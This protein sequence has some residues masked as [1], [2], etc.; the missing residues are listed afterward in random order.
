MNR[1][2]IAGVIWSVFTSFQAIFFMVL[3]LTS[4]AKRE[5][6]TSREWLGR[7]GFPRSAR[8]VKAK[9]VLVQPPALLDDR[10][11][12]RQKVFF[13]RRR[14]GHRRIERR[15]ACHGRIE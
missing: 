15:D 13:H 11:Q 8:D 3:R 12:R 4:R 2:V 1:R 6:P 9:S 14:E 5:S 10:F 7:V